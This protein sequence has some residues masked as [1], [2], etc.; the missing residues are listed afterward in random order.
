MKK[1]CIIIAL[2]ATLFPASA[3]D[4]LTAQPETNTGKRKLMKFDEIVQFYYFFP[5]GGGDNVLNKAN[6]PTL[7]FG[8]SGS[9]FTIYNFYTGPGF[10]YSEYRVTDVA[11]A[12]NVHKTKLIYIFQQFMYKIP[13]GKSISVNP[14]VA[15]GYSNLSQK[16]RST[17]Y[18]EQEG[19]G[20]TLGLNADYTLDKHFMLFTGINYNMYRPKTY[21][22][23][24]YED[25]Y[26]KINQLNFVVGIKI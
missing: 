8:V 22:A 17:S 23:P 21:T 11:L 13:V 12:G 4:S 18:G 24:E 19:I 2:L 14:K 7:S 5:V 25:F 20:F 10:E 9:A 26:K 3:Q 15:I 6:E 1:I 16:N